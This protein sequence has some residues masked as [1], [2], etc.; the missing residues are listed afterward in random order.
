M[1]KAGKRAVRD[2]LVGWAR[3]EIAEPGFRD[4]H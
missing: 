1:E 3:S 2:S 4:D